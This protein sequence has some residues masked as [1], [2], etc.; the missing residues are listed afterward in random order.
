[1]GF[2]PVLCD[3]VIMMT[4]AVVVVV[5]GWYTRV[6]CRRSGLDLD[7]HMEAQIVS[8]GKKRRASDAGAAS[9]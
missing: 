2:V 8:G 1:M 4:V 7:A 6:V 9:I 3:M 5:G